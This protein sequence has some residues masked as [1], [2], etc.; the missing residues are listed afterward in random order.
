M[1]DTR[2]IRKRLMI[3]LSLVVGYFLGQFATTLNPD[4]YSAL[5]SVGFFLGAIGTQGVF[6]LYS[7]WR[8]KRQVS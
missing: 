8:D 3:G 1:N 6:K 4:Q 7:L 5:F 2:E